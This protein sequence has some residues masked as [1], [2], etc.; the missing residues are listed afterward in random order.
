M[1]TRKEIQETYIDYQQT[2]FGGWP[3]SRQ[4]PVHDRH[5][6]RF[7]RYMDGTELRPR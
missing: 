1:N 2:R 3:W 5:K 7:A 4:D 6:G